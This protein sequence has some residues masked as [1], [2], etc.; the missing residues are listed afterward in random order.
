MNNIVNKYK[1]ANDTRVKRIVA[2]ECNVDK[3]ARETY[4]LKS[5]YTRKMSELLEHL[6]TLIEVKDRLRK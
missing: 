2:L 5:N 6:K 1:I 4:T 3:L